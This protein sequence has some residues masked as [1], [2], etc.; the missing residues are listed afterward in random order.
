MSKRLI[1]FQVGEYDIVVA[2]NAEDARKLLFEYTDCEMVDVEDVEDISHKLDVMLYD[3]D[4][5]AI[6][7]LRD[8]VD[9]IDEP[10]YLY[11]WD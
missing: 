9:A 4:G 8:M 7:T 6:E 11:G 10:E 5:V 1:P 2:Y 3:E